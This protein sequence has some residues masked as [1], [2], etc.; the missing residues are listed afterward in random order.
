MNLINI[1]E[2]SS[3]SDANICLGIDFGTTNSVCSIFIDNQFKYIVDS[4]GKKLI[5]T[6]IL[7]ESKNKFFGNETL[8]KKNFLKS[9]FSIKRNFIGDFDEIKYEDNKKNK[10][11][12]IDVSKDFFV[13]LKEQSEKFLKKKVFDCVITVPAY[14]DEKARSG[15]M[16]AAFMA[17]FR[18]RRLI[19]EPTAA[20]FA[21]GLEQ[22]KKGIY[23][24]YDLGGGTFDVSLLKLSKGIFKVIATGGDPKLGGDDFDYL[25]AKNVLK[26]KLNL[27]FDKFTDEEKIKYLKLFKIIKEKLTDLEQV[28]EEIRVNTTNEKII[29]NTN[30]LNSSI[31][32]LIEKTIDISASLLNEAE[33]EI[34]NV[35]GFILVGGS[36]RM[37]LISHKIKKNFDTKI[38]NDINPD[39]AVSKG[40]ALQGYELLNG[41]K[42]ILLDVTPLSLG[43]ETMGGLME[44]IISR[45]SPIPAIKEQT[46]TTHEN[47]QTALKIKVLQGER[48]TSSNNRILG[49]FILSNILPK[50]AGIPRI[51]VIFSLDADGIL[52]VNAKD[53]ETGVESDISL[54]TNE[55]LDL[56]EMRSIVESSIVNAK[57]DIDQRMIIEAKIK[58]K[59]FLNEIES[60]KK[61]IELLCTKND[62]NNINDNINM[63]KKVLNS[64]DCDLINKHVETLNK[65]TE[66]FAQKRI[67][68]NFSGIVGKEIKEIS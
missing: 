6:M 41:S 61:D 20:A 47:G 29:I 24:V 1:D 7:Y 10:V 5:P 40:A 63:L 56:S 59:S 32:N 14:F 28:E 44:K 46:F 66:D 65:S 43:I 48:E 51:K 53:E 27:N 12:S 26:E 16:R 34:E 11:S 15:I 60:A 13:Y 57:N 18:V 17:G 58:A 21:Y 67:E 42:N 8:E 50:P 31:E 68:K 22:R 39:L 37:K 45:N 30:D 64:N 49:E 62:I 25:F 23:F 38:F 2:P 55:N 3:Q 35:D 52:F 36:S 4:F 54:K 33:T 9:I 19:N